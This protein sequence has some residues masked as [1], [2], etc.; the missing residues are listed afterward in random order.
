M[1]QDTHDQLVVAKDVKGK[2][3][4]VNVLFTGNTMGK[5]DEKWEFRKTA[6]HEVPDSVTKAVWDQLG[7]YLCVYGVKKPGPFD[8]E[9][10]SIRIFS[11]MGDLLHV[12][13]DLVKLEG[14]AFRPRPQNILSKKQITALE[15]DYRTKYG[16]QYKEENFKDNTKQ[17]DEVR[18]RKA[19]VINKFLNEFFLPLRKKYEDDMSW[20]EQNWPL[21]PEDMEKEPATINHLYAYGD[22]QSTKK[23]DL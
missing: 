10:R 5:V 16:K 18:E 13:S 4:K 14:F 20:Y 1:Q 22:L 11:L 6:R 7:R 3:G 21:K 8:K 17:Q 23:V 9:K 19:A 15:K 2:K 12:I